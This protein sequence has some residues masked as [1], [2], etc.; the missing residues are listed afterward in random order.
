MRRELALNAEVECHRN[1][2]FATAFVALAGLLLLVLLDFSIERI[3]VELVREILG[4]GSSWTHA[5]VVAQQ[6][7]P[8]T[9]R[10]GF[11][12]SNRLLAVTLISQIQRRKCHPRRPASRPTPPHVE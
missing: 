10:R 2:I 5:H 7:V 9:R 1:P 3:V 12:Q 6:V 11:G 4:K 8:T